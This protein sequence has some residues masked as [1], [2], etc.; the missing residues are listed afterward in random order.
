[1]SYSESPA[2]EKQFLYH[3][4]NHSHQKIHFRL[5]VAQEG[6]RQHLLAK[7]FAYP[8]Q[9]DVKERKYYRVDVV[10]VNNPSSFFCQ[11]VEN[12]EFFNDLME[13]VAA[14]YSGKF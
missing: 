11:F 12:A 7:P 9:S 3:S 2:M 5:N 8:N 4:H 1:M 10:F 6:T 14:V 13:R